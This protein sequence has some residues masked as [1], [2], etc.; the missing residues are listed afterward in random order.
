MRRGVSEA[1]ER[2]VELLRRAVKEIGMPME[3]LLACAVV[4]QCRVM[5][6]MR[7]TLTDL[8]GPE[9]AADIVASVC[10]LRTRLATEK[11]MQEMG[12]RRGEADMTHLAK[13]AKRLWEE[14]FATPY[15]VV[16]A[17]PDEHVGRIR[18]CPY[19]ALLTATIGEEVAKKVYTRQAMI[20]T[21][22]KDFRDMADALGIE[23]EVEVPKIICGGDDECIFIVRR[24]PS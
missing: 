19:F 22:I 9:K 3:E 16:K 10:A 5:Y 13:I 12:L 2:A 20:L 21:E 14:H 24:K 11:Y 17:T 4:A 6:A 23:V 7:R 15:E 1:W 8:F 18:Y